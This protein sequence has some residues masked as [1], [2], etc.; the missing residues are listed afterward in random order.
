MSED[1][2]ERVTPDPA[3][4]RGPVSRVNTRRET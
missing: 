4:Q 2:G 1:A 3:E